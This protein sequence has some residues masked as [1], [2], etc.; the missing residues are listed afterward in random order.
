MTDRM[1]F[2]MI[3]HRSVEEGIAM[4]KGKNT[5]EYFAACSV[6]E[7]NELDM[8]RMGIEENSEV[9]IRSECGEVI[10]TAIRGYQELSPGVCHIRQGVWANQIV[11]ARTQSTGVPQYSGFPVTIEPTH[12]ERV[13]GAKELL[14]TALDMNQEDLC[15]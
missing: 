2:T 13:R 14:F 10:V 1:T 6:I 7:M 3:T 15:Q 8:L 11:P 5:K 12:G 4:E 9:R